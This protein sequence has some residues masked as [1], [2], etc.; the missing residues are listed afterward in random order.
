MF[1]KLALV[2][3]SIAGSDH[4]VLK[5]FA[6][7]CKSSAIP[8]Y[9]MGDRISPV[10]FKLDGCEFY[11]LERQ[12]QTGFELVNNLPERHYGRKNVG[13]LVAIR[14]GATIL[15]ETDDDNIARD[16]FWSPRSRQVKAHD[17]E[18]AGWVNVYGY[19]TQ[20]RIWPRGFALEHLQDAIKPLAS[21]PVHTVDAPI[22]QGLADENPDVD[23]M[24]RLTLPLP[25]SFESDASVAL[26][27]GSWC[28]FNSQNTTWFR[29]AFPLMYLPSHCSFRM[30]DIW[31]SFIAQR[32]AWE[33][34]WKVWF[35][36]ATVYQERNM[37][38]LM[39]DF[40]DEIVGYMNNQR[41]A[42]TL[43]ALPLKKGVS[44]LGDNLLRCYQSMV[45]MKLVGEAELPL[46]EAW[47]NDL[48]R[49]GIEA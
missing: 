3:T 46:V 16:D 1:E 45:E 6:E 41:I 25:I 33:N 20:T 47:I 12:R 36:K 49:L 24:Y 48:R 34:G 29:E 31:R 2:I 10:D 43:E 23:A 5:S 11:S 19:F 22:Q 38:N 15:L 14:E 39:R 26:G 28:P 30:T 40:S 44:E 8:F 21:F 9:V 13:Y 7:T 35:H 17:L 4:P 42:S 27:N 32:I 37:H 18:H